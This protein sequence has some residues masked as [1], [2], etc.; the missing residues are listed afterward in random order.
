MKNLLLLL[1]LL[2]TFCISVPAADLSVYA[3]SGPLAANTNTNLTYTA[4]IMNA[5]T[6]SGETNNSTLT[7]K[8]IGGQTF[9]SLTKPGSWTCTTPS[10]GV[11]GTV[12]CTNSAFPQT[13]LWQPSESVNLNEFRYAS[14]PN[15]HWFKATTAGTTG[16]S[17]PSWNTSSGG[18]TS[19]GSAVW[20]EQG[21]DTFTLVVKI[22]TGTPTWTWTDVYATIS[23]VPTASSPPDPCNEND[24]IDAPTRVNN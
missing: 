1:G 3:F 9:V 20:T 8:F 15:G 11:A 4:N 10:V 13:K 12:T 22:P 24:R 18:T 14:T 7:F 23:F 21:T 6:N 5:S 17:E 19:D 16:S 2:A